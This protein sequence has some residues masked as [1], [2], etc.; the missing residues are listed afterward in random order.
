M[1]NGNYTITTDKSRMIPEDI[2]RWLSG[3]SYWARDIPFDVFKRSFD[4]SFCTGVLYEGRQI[5]FAR[6]ITDYATFAYLA[7][8]FV[9]EEHRGK[10]LSKQMMET[11]FGLDWVEGLR[12]IVLATVDAHGLY[13]QFGFTAPT[14]PERLMERA[15]GQRYTSQ[16]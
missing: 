2:H 8:V 3:Y 1:H 12:R 13:R 6:L 11:I 10:G 7:D 9:T 4:H 15:T 16:S 14:H 5:G